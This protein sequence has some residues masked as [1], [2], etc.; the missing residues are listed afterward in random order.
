MVCKP[1]QRISEEQSLERI[2]WKLIR[3]IALFSSSD[4]E[5]RFFNNTA[6]PTEPVAFLLFVMVILLYSKAFCTNEGLETIMLF[7]NQVLVLTNHQYRFPVRIHTLEKWAQLS[8]RVYHGIK[9]Y[10]CCTEC[11]SMYPIQ[12]NRTRNKKCSWKDS[13]TNANMCGNFLYL[14][15][16]GIYTPKQLFHYNSIEQTIR[17]YLKRQHFVDQLTHRRK[18]YLGYCSDIQDAQAFNTF[19]INPHDSVAYTQESPYNILLSIFVDWFQLYDNNSQDVGGIYAS[20][21]NLQP[22]ERH[23]AHNT[24]TLGIMNGPNETSYLHINHYLSLIVQELQ[25]LKDGVWMRNCYNE[26]VLVKIA[27]NHYQA[28]LPAMRKVIQC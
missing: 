26:E 1:C 20:I 7:L 5:A 11:R 13:Y 25:I 2:G 18:K 27:V 28:D 10:V 15:K 14:E 22:S 23:L 21:Q 17:T 4:F 8:E 16:N 9:S 24:L 6:F 19:K 3:I 12:G